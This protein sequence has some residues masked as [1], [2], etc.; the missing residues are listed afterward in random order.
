M[1]QRLDRTAVTLFYKIVHLK[2]LLIRVW[3]WRSQLRLD[4]LYRLLFLSCVFF[5]QW[6][7]LGYFLA[8]KWNIWLCSF[9]RCGSSDPLSFRDSLG[10]WRPRSRRR[11]LSPNRCSSNWNDPQSDLVTG[12]SLAV[13]IQA[14][15]Q[16]LCAL[17]INLLP[18]KE[19]APCHLP[20]IRI[21]T[22]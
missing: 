12:S 11:S 20:R 18:D 22:G 10:F 14:G 4:L 6:F 19:S 8:L 2:R 9:C 13:V 16:F 7:F 1:S 17:E 21:W 5:L 3:R 15:E